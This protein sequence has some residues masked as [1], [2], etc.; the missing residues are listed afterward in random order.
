MLVPV[1]QVRRVR[2]QIRQRLV[3][4]DVRVRRGSIPVKSVC[5]L[6]MQIVPVRVRV[7]EPV[8]DMRVR[9]PFGEVQPH[10]NA[11]QRQRHPEREPGPLAQ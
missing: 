7:R 1:M 3:F 9:M 8:M 10:A 2:V 4:V 5:M 11:H 6:V